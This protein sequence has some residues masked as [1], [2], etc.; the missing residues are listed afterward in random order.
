MK[1]EIIIRIIYGLSAVCFITYLITK[2]TMFK[3]FG[4]LLLIV[5]SLMLIVENTNKK[6]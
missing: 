2:N 4:G 1:K 6:K 5:A 3:F